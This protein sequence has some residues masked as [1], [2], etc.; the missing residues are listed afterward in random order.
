MKEQILRLL[1]AVFGR[2]PSFMRRGVIKTVS[3]NYTLGAVCFIRRPSDGAILLVR[4][5]Y[6]DRWGTVGGLSKRGEAPHTAVTREAME[7]IGLEIVLRGEPAVFVDAPK[8]RVDIIFDALPSGDADL[9]SVGSTSPEITKVEWFQPDALPDMS[10]E[11][12]DAWTA[13]ERSGARQSPS[14]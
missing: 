2:L 7:E 10:A 9:D 6:T 8:G 11:A 4:H 1:F 13:L 3:P 14:R 12:A 5:S